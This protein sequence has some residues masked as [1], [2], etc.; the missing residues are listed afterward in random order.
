[1]NSEAYEREVLALVTKFFE[2]QPE[3]VD[4]WMKLPNPMLGEV[5]PNQMLERGRGEN[6]LKWVKDSLEENY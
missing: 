4:L 1:M 3:K 5:S 2:T 6:L